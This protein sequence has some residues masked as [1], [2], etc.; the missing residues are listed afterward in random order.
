MH[1]RWGIWL[2]FQGGKHG[3]KKAA[4]WAAEGGDTVKPSFHEA[5]LAGLLKQGQLYLDLNA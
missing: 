3:R 1:T 5:I 4:L 2:Q